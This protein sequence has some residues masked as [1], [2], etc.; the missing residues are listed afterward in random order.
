MP[1]QWCYKATNIKNAASFLLSE[2]KCLHIQVYANMSKSHA[3]RHSKD[4]YNKNKMQVQLK[5]PAWDLNLGKASLSETAAAE[6]K[7]SVEYSEKY[8][9]IC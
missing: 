8:R 2:G 3:Y 7:H 1:D 5:K 4:L 9:A 6:Q